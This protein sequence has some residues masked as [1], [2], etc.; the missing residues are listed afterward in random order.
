MLSLLI[1][2]YFNELSLNLLLITSYVLYTFSLL[3]KWPFVIFPVIVKSVRK[4][5]LNL[6]IIT[7]YCEIW[8]PDIMEVSA[9]GNFN[10]GLS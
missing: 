2:V 1:V 3:Q 4:I 6:K 5:Y 8:L 7:K 10:V 9:V